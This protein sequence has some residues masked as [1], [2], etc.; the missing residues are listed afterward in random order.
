MTKRN[1]IS[2][3][4]PRWYD[5]QRV[6]QND[7]QSEQSRNSGTDA[8]I[9]NN[10]FGSGVLSSS[11]FPNIIFDSDNLTP[12]QVALLA[13]NDFDG[14]GISPAGQPSDTILGNQLEVEYS[15][16][17]VQGPAKA[18]GRLTVK[19]LIIGV[20]FQGNAQYDR[21]TF[22]KREKQVTSKHYARVLSIFFV[23]F[24]GNDN[25]SR[26]LGGKI[27]IREAQ[28]FQLSRDAISISQDTEPNLFFRDF[29]ISTFS[30][31]PNPTVTLYQTLQQGMGSEYTVDS[32]NINTT[33]KRDLVLTD[34][35]SKISEKFLAINN[36]I[37]KI[38]ILLG[39]YKNSSTT[40]DKWFDWS[41]EI[42]FSIFALQTTVS[43]PSDLVP[44]LAIEFD[45]N[46]NPIMQFSLNQKGLKELGYVLNEVLQPIDLIFNASQLGSTTNPV[47]VP[48]KYYAICINRAGDSSIGTIFSGSGSN[49]GTGKSRLSLF[50]GGVWADVPEEDLWFQVWSDAGKVASGQG[51]DSGNG[52]DVEKTAINDVGAVVDYSLGNNPFSDTGQF[53]LNTAIMQAVQ[54]PSNVEQDERTG[55]PVYSTQQ[56]EPS[57]NFVTQASLTQL[58]QTSDP[59]IIG[60]A[61]DVN[62]KTNNIITGIQKYPGLVKGD[63]YTVI[64]PDAN[65]LSQQIIGSKL[66]PND[67]CEGLGYKIY[68]VILCTDGYGDV[69]GDGIIDNADIIRVSQLLGESFYYTATQQKIADGYISALEL[70]RAD[71]NGDGYITSADVNLITQ[72]VSRSINSFPIGSTFTHLDIIV[73]Q[74]IG[75]DDGYY[76]CSDGYIR[77]DGYTGKNIV[78]PLSLTPYEREYDGYY[79]PVEMD[80]IDPIFNTIP[81]SQIP[82]K[83]SPES[84]WKD[85]LLQFSSEARLVPATFTNLDTDNSSIN[86]DVDGNCINSAINNCDD[87]FA[88][89][90]ACNPG[91]N[92]FL[93]PGNLY[94][95]KGQILNPNGTFF[96]Q[97]FEIGQ[98]ILN[99]G[100]SIFDNKSINLFTSFVAEN[101]AGYTDAGYPAMKFA[102]CTFVQNDALIKN[103]IKFDVAIQSIVPNVDGYSIQDG[104]GIIVDDLI[105]IFIDSTTGI[106]TLTAKDLYYQP[107]YRTLITK[108]QVM[109]FLKKAGWNN[110]TL[111]ITPTQLTG[112]FH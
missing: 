73:Q 1:P 72:Y 94:I 13:S 20:D 102:D 69:N 32:L 35:N 36:N 83:I 48:G 108:I 10:H 91:R 58:K 86:R 27:I 76:D 96:K 21:F 78:D 62:P 19:V 85:W 105:G 57:F 51:Y 93:I 99:L 100:S 28:S 60:C 42:I 15:N 43:S 14:T 103:Q 71:V 6:D 23:D 66:I 68:D 84:F 37:Q 3:I 104:Y 77:L 95:R 61:R 63:K 80:I 39:N 56:Y 101:L 107:A 87:P 59:V 5:G 64:N 8:A 75:R 34:V 81:F 65:L 38:T 49:T 112:L 45:P 46:P 90:N 40:V 79:I 29:K 31:V 53:T 18:L 82:F 12:D 92:D 33:Y 109:I 22:T 26:D 47:I 55:S 17:D 110:Q 24:L 11:I 67:N 52:I 25:C 106:M 16:S 44:G 89:G 111:D 7:M 97:D 2:I 98:I 88:F 50:N 41:G 30:V 70:L 54:T 9:V 4:Q 74:N